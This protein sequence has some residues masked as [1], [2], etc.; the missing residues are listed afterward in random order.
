MENFMG[1]ILML[2]I[3]LFAGMLLVY[4]MG[5]RLG[6]AKLAR[7][8]N[9]TVKGVG[10]A[11]A[12]VFGLLGLILAFTFNGAGERYEARRHLITEEANAIGT[13]YLRLDVLPEDAQ[14]ELRDLFRRY[15]GLRAETYV[16]VESLSDAK[17]QLAD[18]A[19][20]QGQMWQRAMAACRRPETPASATIILLPALNEMIDITTTQEMAT[21]NHPPLAVFL[22]LDVL[23]LASTLLMGYDTALSRERGR[24]YMFVFAASMVIAM[25][26]TAELE[27]PRL[28]L[29]RVDDANQILLELRERMD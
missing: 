25:Y 23:A 7:S 5:W 12:S 8:P 27:F 2:A 24:F 28:G 10:A 16:N 9:S 20:M 29:I 21:R 22:T 3:T 1:L 26:V 18:C 4:E 17:R 11:V 19:A 15:T 14:P 13:A 6:A